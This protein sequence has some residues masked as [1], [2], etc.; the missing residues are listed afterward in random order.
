MTTVAQTIERLKEMN[1]EAE[2]IRVLYISGYDTCTKYVDIDLDE[3][4]NNLDVHTDAVYF[5]WDRG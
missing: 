4:S 1:P 5:G 3:Y 2:G